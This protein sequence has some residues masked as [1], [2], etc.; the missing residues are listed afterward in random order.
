MNSR[1]AALIARIRSQRGVST[2]VVLLTLT[3]GILIGTV[4]SHTGVKGNFARSDAALLPMQTPQQLG[5]TFGQVAKQ[6]APSVVNISTESTSKPR[7]RAAGYLL[8]GRS[9]MST[10]LSGS[11]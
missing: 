5:T 9:R 11:R 7:R 2:L 8:R 1:F 6:V 10:R 3:T 4:L